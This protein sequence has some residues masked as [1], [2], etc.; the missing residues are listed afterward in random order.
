M[1]AERM[2]RGLA[3]AVG[4]AVAALGVAA[5]PALAGPP[6]GTEHRVTVA[7]GTGS[8]AGPARVAATPSPSAPTPDPT[9]AP[10]PTAPVRIM[11]MGDSITGS[12]GCWRGNLWQQ[13]DEAGHEVDFVGGESQACNPAG[14]DPDHEGHGGYLVT[15]SVEN[16]DTRRWLE[17]N[18]PDVLLLHFGTNDVW[19]NLPPDQILDAY[20]SI[21]TDL[22]EL[23]PTATV[24]VAQIIPLEP[25][26]E[27][28]CTDCPERAV[29]LNARIPD[30]AAEQSTEESPVVVVDQW[31]GFD[32]ATD[33]YDGVH[34]D[35]EGN[36]KIAARW[37]EALDQVLP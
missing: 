11:P 14:S 35:E 25:G 15:Q 22:R 17:Q 5:V 26:A 34:P 8:G 23:N 19:S 37:F 28:G 7:D 33:T 6:A 30:W 4:A 13:L 29:N 2:R 18:T 21:V 9:D 1:R 36:V 27:F 20:T 24:L 16:G 32:P 12:P 10:S 31:T 3:I